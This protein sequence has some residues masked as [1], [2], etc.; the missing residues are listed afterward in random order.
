MCPALTP[1][2]SSSLGFGFFRDFTLYAEVASRGIFA[3]V[4]VDL[5][6]RAPSRAFEVA[7]LPHHTTKR[8]ADP[9]MDPLSGVAS[10]FAVASLAL[11][12][13]QTVDTVKTFVKDVK[14]ASKELERL[15][16]LLDRLGALLQDVRELMER[17]T[18]LEH[19]PVPSNTIFACLKSCETSLG[20]LEDVV[21]KYGK[22][23]GSNPSAVKRW[24]DDLKLAFEAKDIAT[25]ELRIQ[26]LATCMQLIQ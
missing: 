12:L 10:V 4:R 1:L 11:Q 18:S 20:L 19:F 8:I 21:K 17:Q 15:A 7:A 24:K 5:V 3:C 25:F 6:S 16:E 13:I 22:V 9:D 26:T 14:G 2:S 23:R